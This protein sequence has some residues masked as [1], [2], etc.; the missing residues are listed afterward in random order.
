MT[1]L[2]EGDLAPAFSL[3]RGGGGMLDLKDLRGRK[4]VLYFYPKDDTQGCTAEAIDFSAMK[5]DFEAAGAMV[6]GVSPD[7]PKRHTNFASKYDLS[8]DLVSDEAL[9]A[10]NAY[11][12]WVEKS[13]YG[14]SFMGVERSTFLIDGD[15][16]IRRIWRKVRVPGH[17]A[18]V[19]EAVRCLRRN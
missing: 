8:I 4:V 18:D 17:A 15:G 6:V 9:Q 19:L 12:V 14:R 2:S 3:P 11:G 1:E 16:H 5:Q 10:V 7:S 13:M